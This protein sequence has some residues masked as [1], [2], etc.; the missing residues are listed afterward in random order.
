MFCITRSIAILSIISRWTNAIV[1]SLAIFALMGGLAVVCSLSTLVDIWK[2]VHS[3]RTA[4]K[5]VRWW[6]VL[7]NRTFLNIHHRSYDMPWYIYYFVRWPGCFIHFYSKRQKQLA[8]LSLVGGWQPSTQHNNKIKI[9]KFLKKKKKQQQQRRSQVVTIFTTSTPA[10]DS[11]AIGGMWGGGGG[12]INESYRKK[13]KVVERDKTFATYCILKILNSSNK[14][15]VNI[16]ICKFV[17]L[18]YI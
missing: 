14:D 1:S 18:P 9:F 4:S 5:S 7:L 8:C 11:I 3:L 12:G 6:C 17:N 15:G 16:K 10:Q 13:Q 2:Y